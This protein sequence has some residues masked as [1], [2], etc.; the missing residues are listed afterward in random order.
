MSQPLNPIRRGPRRRCRRPRAGL[1]IVEALISIAIS[2]A[3]LTAVA[4]AIAVTSSA[5]HINDEFVRANQ[6]ARVTVNRIVEDVRRCGGVVVAD[7]EIQVTRTGGDRA[8]YAY[9]AGAQ[10]M[11][12]TLPD[13]AGNPTYVL[14]QGVSAMKFGTD[15]DTVSLTMTVA[16]GKNTVTLNGSAM[17]RRVAAFN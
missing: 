17:P 4:A 5:M 15:G 7:T 14:A 3:L 8:I 13:A 2:A 12:L 6:S 9:D 10:R 1:G 11:T 16:R